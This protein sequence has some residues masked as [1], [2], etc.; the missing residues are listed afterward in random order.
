M[1]SMFRR[2]PLI[3]VVTFAYLAFVGYITLTPEP[4]D[5]GTD[6]F[7]WQVLRLLGHHRAT[8]WVTYAG[9]EFWANVGMFLPIG[10]FFLL[11]L[12]RGRWWL[13]MLLG[14]LL[15]VG[16]E[17]TQYFFFPS[18]VADVRDVISNTTGAVI[19]V[20]V[21]LVLTAAKARELRRRR[22]PVRQPVAH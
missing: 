18:R 22:V 13:A 16:I 10:M 7:I 11:L 19:G 15:S 3:S 17:T 2:H 5:E 21:V 9:V 6:S 1:V 8:D 4:I 20:V 14:F 12:G